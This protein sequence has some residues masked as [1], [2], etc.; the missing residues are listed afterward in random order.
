V[1]LRKLHV[2][3]NL[4]CIYMALKIGTV[5]YTMLGS[6]ANLQMHDSKYGLL[7]SYSQISYRDFT[8]L[9]HLLLYFDFL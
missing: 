2:A 9:G 5:S 8:L 4:L 7:E 1:L 3:G 6:N